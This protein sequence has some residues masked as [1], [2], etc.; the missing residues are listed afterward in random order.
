LEPRFVLSGAGQPIDFLSWLNL[1]VQAEQAA[2]GQAVR[3]PSI[4]VHPGQSIQAAVDVAAPGTLILLDPG[5]YQQAITITKPDIFLVGLGRSGSDGVVITNP[6][7]MDNGINVTAQGSGFAL[8]NLAVR[9]FGDNGVLLTGVQRFLIDRVIANNDGE[10]GVFPVH[11]INGVVTRSSVSGNS[12]TGIYVGQS[13]NVFLLGNSAFGNVNGIEVENSVNVLVAGNHSFNNTAGILIDLLPGLDFPFAANILVED[14]V[15]QN[16]NLANFGPPGDIASVVPSGTGILVL[17]AS[18]T[19]V[20]NNLIVGNR[21]IGV[22]LLSSAVL[23]FFGGGPVV[24]I[25]PD[26]MGTTIENNLVF[27]GFGGADLLWDG[28]GANNCWLNNLFLTSLS[29][30]PLPT[31]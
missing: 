31:C 27:G 16:N 22:G 26:P 18:Q 12:D 25:E 1:T 29:P 15:V 3:A 17:G 9:N 19:V 24:G 23:T 13:A 2:S 20:Q 14:N 4:E 7:G 30:G 21:T 5:T 11:S 10:Y 28:S 8:L 6:G